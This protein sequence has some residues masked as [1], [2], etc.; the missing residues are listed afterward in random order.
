[1]SRPARDRP[2]ESSLDPSLQLVDLRL[3]QASDVP[4]DLADR[5]EP[6]LD[7]AGD[8]VDQERQDNGV[9]SKREH[10]V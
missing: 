10:A 8:G 4:F 2:I 1:V 7:Q 5:P 6:K 3:F 9:E